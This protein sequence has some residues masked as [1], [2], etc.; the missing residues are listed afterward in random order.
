LVTAA[1]HLVA[2]G[3]KFYC[4]LDR[5]AG[6]MGHL[7]FVDS[8]NHQHVYVVELDRLIAQLFAVA[9]PLTPLGTPDVN[10]RAGAPTTRSLR[11][12]GRWP[13]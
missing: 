3:K 6:T 13:R 2:G 4:F 8:R 7:V 9:Q 10:V 12:P 5:A 11:G 1:Y